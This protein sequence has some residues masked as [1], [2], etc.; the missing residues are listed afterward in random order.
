MRLALSAIAAA[1]VLAPASAAYCHG[2]PSPDAQPNLNPIDDSEPV[3][4]KTVKNGKL[5]RAGPE[6]SQFH[7]VHVYGTAYER[8]YAHG[9]LLTEDIRSFVNETWAYIEDSAAGALSGLP[10]KLRDWVIEAGADVA[11]GLTDVLTAP[12]T[13]EYFFDELHGLADASGVNYTVIKWIHLL[14]EVTRGQCSMYGLWGD[15]TASTNKTLQLRAL[16]WDTEGPYRNYPSVLIEHPTDG[17]HAW[18]SQGFV[19]WIGALTGMSE[20]QMGISEIGVSYPDASFGK[21]SREGVPFTYLLRDILQFDNSY[22][23][24]IHRMETAK[25]TC[26][27]ILGVG[28]GKANASTFRAF[29][30]SAS[31]CNVFDDTNMMPYNQTW[32]PRIKNTVYYG[33]D[34]LCPNYSEVLAQRIQKYYGTVTPELSIKEITAIVQ[35]GD[36]HLAVYD[37]TDSQMYVSFMRNTTST[38]GPEMAYDRSFTKLDLAKLFNE[39]PPAME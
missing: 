17:G 20:K 19:G 36:V 32:H 14:G 15:A 29:E 24:S 7:L 37:L 39:Q 34:W 2:A 26:D 23:D 35:T 3:L 38:D 33:M 22:E 31:V 1:I 6:G 28:D 5:Y 4:V 8:G 9:E 27:L 12:Y 30:Y 10:T 11:F 13:G 21:M 25:R 16:D 18:A